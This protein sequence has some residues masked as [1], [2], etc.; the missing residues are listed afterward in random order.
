MPQKMLY[1]IVYETIAKQL[2]GRPKHYGAMRIEAETGDD[3]MKLLH[4]A[5]GEPMKV[6]EVERVF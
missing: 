6:M 4:V 5:I 1:L 3:M 2:N